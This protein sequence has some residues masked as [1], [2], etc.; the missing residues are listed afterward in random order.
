[1]HSSDRKPDRSGRHS[2]IAARLL[3]AAAVA[4]VLL[5]MEF[6]ASICFDTVHFADY[7]NYGESLSYIKDQLAGIIQYYDEGGESGERD[8]STG[9]A[10]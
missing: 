5:G 8:G 4:A 2:K 9:R 10:G 1:M 3:T 7:Y 6:L